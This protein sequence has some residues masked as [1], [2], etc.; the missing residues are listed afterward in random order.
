MLDF[1]N[2]VEKIGGWLTK[3]EGIFLYQTASKVSSENRIVEIGSWKG[4]STICLG[5]GAQAGNKSKI[6]A[7][8]PH[9]GSSK[10]QRMF[11]ELD[12]Y[13]EFLQ[14]IKNAKA[15]ECI[16]PV[17]K[18]SNEASKHFNEPIGFLFVDGA[19]DFKS[20]QLDIKSWFSKVKDGGII[21]FHDSW[22][23][24]GP[25]CATAI[26]L[27][28]SPKI[29]NPRLVGTITYFEKVEKNSFYDRLRNIFFLLYRIPI[30]WVGTINLSR[31]GTVLK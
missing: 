16:E 22:G 29:K 13:Q 31:K 1:E 5:K 14:N 8:D 24:L 12:T 28:T 25:N 10:L 23:H 7:V 4:K 2:D 11:G 18:T 21:A 30:G 3:A 15:D 17:L 9:I 20:V 26:L 27:L 6:Y 19:H